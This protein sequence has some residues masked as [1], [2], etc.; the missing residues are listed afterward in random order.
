[1]EHRCSGRAE[2]AW[3]RSPG[4]EK[5]LLTNPQQSQ[6]EVLSAAGF[7]DLPHWAAT[8]AGLTRV[9]AVTGSTSPA[10][11]SHSR[12]LLLEEAAFCRISHHWAFLMHFPP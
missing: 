1:M 7:S 2:V 11:L 10:R 5:E 4:W 6:A 3:S 12:T 9:R 8:P